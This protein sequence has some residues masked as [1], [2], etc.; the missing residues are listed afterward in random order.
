[1]PVVLTREEMRR[2][3]EALDGQT[4]LMAQVMYG[5]GLRLMELIR[6]RVK[7]VDVER[8]QIAVRD[9]KGGKDRVT[10]LP[11]VVLPELRKHLAT[12]QHLYQADRAADV[13][14]VYLPAGL[15]RKYPHRCICRPD[16]SGNIR[17]RGWNGRGNGCGPAGS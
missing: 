17:T 9:G 2:R 4:R 6:L 12:I 5:G 11:E 1:M 15:E 10:T 13:A 16:W 14:P 7:D 8:R 3:L